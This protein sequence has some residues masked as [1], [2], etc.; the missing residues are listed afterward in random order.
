MEQNNYYAEAMANSESWLTTAAQLLSAASIAGEKANLEW[1]RSLGDARDDGSQILD[2]HPLHHQRV[3][4]MLSAFAIENL[5]K[6]ILV[7]RDPDAIRGEVL[8]IGKLPRSLK[9]HDLNRLAEQVGLSLSEHENEL[10]ER[11]S[12]N[13]TWIGRYPVPATLHEYATAESRLNW[14][15]R[16]TQFV[17]H[18]VQRIIELAQTG[19]EPT[20][21]SIEIIT[22]W[23]TANEG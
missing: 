15:N 5:F 2:L 4:M 3:H 20:T 21:P 9:T 6:F 19:Q 18:L 22:K 23:V 13:S 8:K 14:S 12:T 17:A 1:Q 7:S 16:D 10:L 11:L